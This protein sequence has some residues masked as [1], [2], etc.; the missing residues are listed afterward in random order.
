MAQGL[1]LEDKS[2]RQVRVRGKMIKFDIVTLNEFLETLV[3]LDPRERYLAYS[4]FCST[5]P[6]P[7]ELATRLCI[8][9]R[10]FVLN[11]EG[12]P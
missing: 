4:R 1:D 6:N 9:G 11:A 8:P 3:I 2:P 12:A 10:G 7:Q 5:H